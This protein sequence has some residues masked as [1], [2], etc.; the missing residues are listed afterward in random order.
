MKIC[1]H[2]GASF[3]PK[4]PNS[5]LCFPCWKKRERALE[6]YDSLRERVRELEQQTQAPASPLSREILTK[7]I[8][9][10]HPDRHGNSTMSNEVTRWLLEQ[11]QESKH[12]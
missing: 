5:K 10:C 9:L 12:R 4:Y 7:L 8:R 2:C 6:Q 11:R 1:I 3:S